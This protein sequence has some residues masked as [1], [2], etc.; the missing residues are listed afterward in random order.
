MIYLHDHITS[1]TDGGYYE[2]LTGSFIAEGKLF[3]QSPI[4]VFL[5][6]SLFTLI[7]GGNLTFGI[8]ISASLFFAAG[9]VT[10]YF[11]ARMTW[12]RKVATFT[13]PFSALSII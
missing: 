6:T 10:N 1:G 11:A 9:V 13:L 2:L 3:Y 5:F 7:S 8:T 12:N 4:I